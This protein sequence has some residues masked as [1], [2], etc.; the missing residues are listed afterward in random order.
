MKSQR[1]P[2]SSLDGDSSRFLYHQQSLISAAQGKTPVQLVFADNTTS[3]GLSSVSIRDGFIPIRPSSNVSDDE[4]ET[5]I[6]LDN[7]DDI[8]LVLTNSIEG[9][10]VMR[11][12]VVATTSLIFLQ[13]LMISVVHSG[14]TPLHWVSTEFVA[15]S[16][17]YPSIGITHLLFI[18]GVYTSSV[19]MLAIYRASLATIAIYGFA[20][21][22]GGLLCLAVMIMSIPICLC[23]NKVED[24][25]GPRCMHSFNRLDSS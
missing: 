13:M 19:N 10:T 24:L 4:Q 3:I 20:T 7:A 12:W 9:Q 8:I 6:T 23:A 5:S 16:C 18:A 2:L 21:S 22:F 17:I 25:L 15:S 14:E 11:G 1:V